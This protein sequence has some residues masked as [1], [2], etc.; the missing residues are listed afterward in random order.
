M[1]LTNPL[2][3]PLQKNG[4]A[5]A[6]R[7][8]A[9]DSDRFPIV[10][11]SH[12]RWDWVWQRPQQFLSRL[13]KRHP[14]LFIEEP[15]AVAGLSKPCTKLR[16]VSGLPNVRVVQTE[17][18]GELFRER[19]AVDEA[20]YRLVQQTLAGPLGQTFRRPVQWFYDPMAVVP[21]GGRMDERVIVYDCMD[22]LSQFRGAPPELVRRERELLAIADVVFAG[23]PKIHSAKKEFNSNCHSYGCGVDVRHFGQARRADTVVPADIATLPGPVLGYF[24]VV[25]ERMDYDLVA[26]LADVHPEWSIVIIGP[27]TK[28]DP[29]TF[30]QRANL[31]WLGGRDYEQLPGYVKGLDVCLMPFAINEATAFINPTKALEYMATGRPIVSTAI[32]DVVLQFADVVRIANSREAFIGMCEQALAAPDH[33]RTGRGMELASRNSWEA[34]VSRLEGH[35]DDALHSQEKLEVRAA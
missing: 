15:L 26:Q 21:F 3:T 31:H 6:S 7:S 23:G 22:Q 33:A 4:L 11:H 20:Q 10:V 28:V 5:A 1:T 14:V 32:E 9:S 12:L 17:L 16:E 2:S 24:G 29:A 19:E 18:P 34:I 27:C 25:D 8:D 30:P 35:I 13:S